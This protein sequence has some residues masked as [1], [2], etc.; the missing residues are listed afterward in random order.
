MKTLQERILESGPMGV[1]KLVDLL[2]DE[3]EVIR[4]DVKNKRFSS[5]IEFLSK[6]RVLGASAS[7]N[8]HR[9]ERKYSENRRV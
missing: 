2:H 6:R 9:F 8:S 4:N 5:S 3:R 7:S 1:S